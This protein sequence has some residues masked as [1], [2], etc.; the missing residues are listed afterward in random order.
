MASINSKEAH[1]TNN[2]WKL[3]IPGFF[4]DSVRP[5]AS[6]S[7]ISV[8]DTVSHELSV[9]EFQK[10]KS[11]I[12]DIFENARVFDSVLREEAAKLKPEELLDISN[13]ML[14]EIENL[15][16]VERH[17]IEERL[18]D[19]VEY[20]LHSLTEKSHYKNSGK[21]Y[22]S[23]IHEESKVHPTGIFKSLNYQKQLI[24]PEGITLPVPDN[25]AHSN[26]IFSM[27]D[28]ATDQ[29]ARGNIKKLLGSLAL[30]GST[31]CWS[32][33][34]VG[35]AMEQGPFS[36][37]TLI[38]TSMLNAAE[39]VG[40]DVALTPVLNKIDMDSQTRKKL[41][42]AV[43]FVW[44][45]LVVLGS[46]VGEASLVGAGTY[47]KLANLPDWLRVVMT[48]VITSVTVFGTDF[49]INTALASINAMR[50]SKEVPNHIRHSS[51]Q[52]PPQ[53]SEGGMAPIYQRPSNNGN[54]IRRP[55][56]QNFDE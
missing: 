28:I 35:N 46:Y 2:A 23:R 49:S 12:P 33:I 54:T 21:A 42:T 16:D 29:A 36:S 5:I 10:F 34:S 32:L 30:M 38:I 11:L 25:N 19:S 50:G 17:L 14:S 7:A 6:L 3:L 13:K 1:Q 31:F 20:I 52:R 15:S 47:Q 8:I 53:Q 48:G 27:A 39:M 56:P 9:E 45:G 40:V 43:Q 44:F 26:I 41:R 22:S 18:P 37:E 51:S 55:R 24:T 4:N